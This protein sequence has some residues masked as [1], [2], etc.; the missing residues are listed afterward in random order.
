MPASAQTTQTAVTWPEGVIARYLTDAGKAIG[1]PTVTVDL[2]EKDDSVL[3]R[4]TVCPD[5]EADFSFDPMCTGARATGWATKQ[6][7]TWA[8]AHA[9][10]C[11]ALPRPTA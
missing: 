1:D 8:Q 4:C 7:A 9:E 3:A 10:V 6:A 11:R 5:S 2:I